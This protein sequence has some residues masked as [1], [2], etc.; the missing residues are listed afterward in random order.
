[1]RLKALLI[2]FC[3]LGILINARPKKVTNTIEIN[4]GSGGGFTGLYENYRLSKS[5]ALSKIN[6]LKDSFIKTISK[7][8]HQYILKKISSQ[9][10]LKINLQESGNMNCYIDIIKAGK[11][12]KKFQWPLGKSGLPKQVR[13]IDSLLNSI[14]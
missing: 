6:N 11:V 3:L 10:L 1:M 8:K 7:S 14:L 13:E 9:N 5:G 4:F 12:V 2:L